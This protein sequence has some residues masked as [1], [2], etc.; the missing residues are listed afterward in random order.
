MINHCNVRMN[1]VSRC[2]GN[3]T[4]S[5]TDIIQC[6]FTLN[7]LCMS[8]QAHLMSYLIGKAK[9]DLLYT[10]IHGLLCP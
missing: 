2:Q 4:L 10:S 6:L 9:H 7:Q 3:F 5:M 8:F 1:S